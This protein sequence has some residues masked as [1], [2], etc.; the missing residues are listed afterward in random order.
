MTTAVSDFLG[1]DLRL[2]QS[3]GE[4]LL[5]SATGGF[6]DY[7]FV[8]FPFAKLYEG[9]LKKL[10][11]QIGAINKFQ[12]ENDRW[13]VGRA[14]N[15]QLEKDLR[16]EESVYDRIA[17]LCGGTDLPDTLWRAWKRGRNQIFHFY[18]TEFKPLSLSEARE[19]ISE[20]HFAME[21]ALEQCKIIQVQ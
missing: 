13:R 17:N 6:Y 15:P 11:F 10:F 1:N 9:F 4:K 20:F 16:H 21:S 18:P 12:Y 7:S 3:D 8:V 14:L 19:I 5:A 2:L